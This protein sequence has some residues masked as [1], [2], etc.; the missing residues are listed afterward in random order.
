M[1]CFYVIGE[2]LLDL[3]VVELCNYDVI[4]FGVIGDLLVLS[5]VLECGLLL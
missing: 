5:G 3:V 1:W 4:L 2:V